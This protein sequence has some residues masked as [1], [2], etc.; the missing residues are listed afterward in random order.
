MSYEQELLAYFQ[1]LSSAHLATGTVLLIKPHPRDDFQKIR[2]LQEQLS[3]LFA[4]IIVLSEPEL[5]FLPFEVFFMKAFM[6]FDVLPQSEVCPIQ[7]FA[8]S[9]AC[10]SLRLLFKVPSIIGFGK[11]ITSKSFYKDYIEGRLEHERI[12]TNA[13]GAMSQVI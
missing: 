5:F 9:S 6:S 10:L 3:G 8:V 11:N 7:V 2:Q 13:I 1:F 4:K 12:L